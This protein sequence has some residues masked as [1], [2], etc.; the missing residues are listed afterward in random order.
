MDEKYSDPAKKK[1]GL[2]VALVFNFLDAVVFQHFF[3]NPYITELAMLRNYY[4]N[5]YC[6][7]VYNLPMTVNGAS[8]A[9][10]MYIA[11]KDELTLRQAIEI[12]L[13]I[14]ENTVEGRLIRSMLN[15]RRDDILSLHKNISKHF[16]NMLQSL[17]EQYAAMPR[18]YRALFSCFVSM[19]MT[20]YLENQSLFPMSRLLIWGSMFL[21]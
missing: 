10:A 18:L 9:F 19:K 6:G 13:A 1:T 17:D 5:P 16:K 11:Y 21:E 8:V 20:Q 3:E 2:K 7:N 4:F 15:I 12:L 14:L